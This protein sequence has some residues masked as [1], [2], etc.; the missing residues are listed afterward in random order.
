MSTQTP[1]ELTEQL[2]MKV[3]QSPWHQRTYEA[4]RS[5][6]LKELQ[7]RTKERIR[8]SDCRWDSENVRQIWREHHQEQASE[9][10]EKTLTFWSWVE[11]GCP[12]PC[13][14]NQDDDDDDD[15]D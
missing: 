2:Y 9:E 5:Q 11:R 1:N 14:E 12:R 13:S 10:A 4:W 15:D 8:E 6:Q 3:Q 7:L